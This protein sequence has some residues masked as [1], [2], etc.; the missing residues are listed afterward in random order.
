MGRA[1]PQL[2][3]AAS[4]SIGLPGVSDK[5]IYGTGRSCPRGFYLHHLTAISATIAHADALTL[6]NHA[7]TL[8]FPNVTTCC[9]FPPR[10]RARRPARRAPRLR[11][12]NGA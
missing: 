10:D 9:D 12:H 6:L 3:R 8:N 5:T 2:L 1:L 11:S 7:S 4:K